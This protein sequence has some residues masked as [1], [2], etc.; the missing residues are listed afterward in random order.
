MTALRTYS[1]LS[2]FNLV[3]LVTEPTRQDNILDLVLASNTTL[4]PSITRIPGLSDHDIVCIEAAVKPTQTKQKSKK[5]H[6]YYKA[7]WTDFRSKLKDYQTE[8]LKDNHGKSVEQLWS[9]LTDKLDQLTDQCIPTKV[10]KG[11]PSLPWIS[12]VKRDQDNDPQT[13]QTV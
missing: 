3:Q 7:D 11:K 4:I 8:F 9:E 1:L 6:L 13:Q 2:D 10:I 5:I 12:R